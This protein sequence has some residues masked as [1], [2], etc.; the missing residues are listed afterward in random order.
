MSKIILVI[1]AT[2]AI[3]KETCKHFAAEKAS[4]F[5]VGRNEQKLQV[6]ERDLSARGAARVKCYACDLLDFSQHGKILDEAVAAYGKLDIVFIAHGV[7]PDQQKAQEQYAVAEEAIR[8]NF[9]SVVSLL[10]PIATYLEKQRSGMLAVLSSVAG[11]RGRAS[12]YVY[13]ATK[14]GLNVFLEGLW[15]RLQRS[16]VDVLNIKPG[17]IDSPMTAHLPKGLLFSKIEIAGL[18][19]YKAILK[20]KSVAYIPPYWRYIMLVVI[21]MPRFLFKRM[22]F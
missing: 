11:D 22:N 18:E 6:I 13:A 12:S 3:A 20:R 10:T 2:S 8:V 4:F 16:G 19:I 5:L 14:G 15:Q 17:Y 7:L 9:L 21:H 1:G